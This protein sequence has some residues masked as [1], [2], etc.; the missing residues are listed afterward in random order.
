MLRD[1]KRPNEYERDSYFLLMRLCQSQAGNN[2]KEG[3][4]FEISGEG[5]IYFI[6]VGHDPVDSAAIVEDSAWFRSFKLS[7]DQPRSHLTI[8]RSVALQLAGWGSKRDRD[9]DL[10]VVSFCNWK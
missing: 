2:K 3:K 10:I 7:I 1:M 5:E 6:L 9:R 4:G 8:F